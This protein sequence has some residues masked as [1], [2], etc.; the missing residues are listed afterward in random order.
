MQSTV[1]LLSEASFIDL[2]I[3]PHFV[4]LMLA[5][6]AVASAALVTAAVRAERRRRSEAL[7]KPRIVAPARPTVGARIE[8]PMA[9]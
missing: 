9:A 1:L 6:L 2:A 5:L 3:A 7:R 8:R 4:W